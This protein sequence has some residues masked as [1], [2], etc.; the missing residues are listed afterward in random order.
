MVALSNGKIGLGL[1]DRPIAH[2]S[3]SLPAPHVCVGQAGSDVAV[4][5]EGKEGI[6]VKLSKGGLGHNIQYSARNI[7][8]NK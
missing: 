1:I 7:Q 8:P 6:A 4:R 3:L 2:S 5:I